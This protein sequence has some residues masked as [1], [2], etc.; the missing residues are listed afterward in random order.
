MH[1]KKA[2]MIWAVLAALAALCNAQS[3]ESIKRG[4]FSHVTQWNSCEPPLTNETCLVGDNIPTSG[5][6]RTNSLCEGTNQSYAIILLTDFVQDGCHYN[7]WIWSCAQHWLSCTNGSSCVCIDAHN[8]STCAC[9]T[10]VTHAHHCLP[11]HVSTTIPTSTPTTPTSTPTTSVT[12]TP[13]TFDPTSTQ[14]TF[15]PT[16]TPSLTTF[17]TTMCPPDSASQNSKSESK[18][19][20]MTPWWIP[21][22][23]ILVG[24]A[25][26]ALIVVIAQRKM[27]TRAISPATR[28]ASFYNPVYGDVPP[29]EPV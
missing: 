9:E 20:E 24:V 5:C 19:V 16:S 27:A 3:N 28:R 2:N 11:E 25:V 7:L 10:N 23:C 18:T 12:S 6:R 15:D 26:G 8:E 17:L 29:P 14:T 21:L 1:L 22:V 13:T 4:Y